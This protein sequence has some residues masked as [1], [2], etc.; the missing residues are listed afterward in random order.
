MKIA[1][2][3][4]GSILRINK[5]LNISDGWKEDGPYLPLEFSYITKSGIL[6][7]AITFGSPSVQTLW[8]QADFEDLQTAIKNLEKA[9]R[10]SLNDIGYVSNN[11]TSLHSSMETI[12]SIK[13]WMKEKHIEVSIWLDRKSNFY[14]VTEVM[15]NEDNALDYIIGLPKNQS[16]SA[17]RYVVNN[18]E[19]IETPLRKRLREELSWRN[20]SVY[21]EGFWLDKN[22]FIM[23]DK[24]EIE[25]VKRETYSSHLE[26]S[27]TVPMLILT[28]AVKM[29]VDNKNKILGEDK[30]EKL[31]LWLP[32]VKSLYQQQSLW[33]KERKGESEVRAS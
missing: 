5:A 16:L 11:D 7:L 14:K 23:C 15:F 32:D 3:G 4:W 27:E 12:D 33:L 25:M 22:S 1:I 2:V 30:I 8:A 18:P 10:A 29:M 13:K 20:L 6:T 26:P 21:R 24:V 19:Q 17:E 31:G 28:N 9:T